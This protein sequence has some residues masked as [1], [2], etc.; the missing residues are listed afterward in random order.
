[1]PRTRPIEE[2]FWEKVQKTDGCWLWTASTNS[3]GYGSLYRG[4]GD[5]RIAAHRLSY[6][7]HV[8]PV[9]DGLCVLHSCDVRRCVNPAHLSLGTPDDNMRDMR[10]R[11]R[12]RYTK[13]TAGGVL[14]IRS[15][16]ANGETKAALAREF[17]VAPATI[18]KVVHRKKWRHVA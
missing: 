13:L 16:A 14:E 7:L 8:G 5:F 9:P 12:Q 18:R 17:G 11:D 6:E 10:V 2:R 3:C 1:M 15:R 4:W